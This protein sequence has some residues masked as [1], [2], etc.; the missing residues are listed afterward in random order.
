[1]KSCLFILLCLFLGIQA[2]A[3]DIPK[4]KYD[5]CTYTD[6]IRPDYGKIIA[7]KD[8]SKKSIMERLYVLECHHSFA[9]VITNLSDFGGHKKSAPNEAI[10]RLRTISLV[11]NIDSHKKA[12]SVF[13][14]LQMPAQF[15]NEYAKA[16]EWSKNER[17]RPAKELLELSND[18]TIKEENL[19]ELFD[20]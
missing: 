5:G 8:F 19:K 15:L 16:L 11:S 1:M 9:L 18:F 7:Q 10:H 13:Q 4:D 14:D 6:I 2:H 3:S 12:F 20:I 17:Q